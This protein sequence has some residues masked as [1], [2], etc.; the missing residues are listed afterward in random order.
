MADATIQLL[1]Y[2]DFA[3]TKALTNR[4]DRPEIRGRGNP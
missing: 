3:K 2:A 4:F 1:A